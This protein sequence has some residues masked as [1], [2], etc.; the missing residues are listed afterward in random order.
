MIVRLH[1][2]SARA[3][4]P[5]DLG[6]ITALMAACDEMETGGVDAHAH[7][8]DMRK[9]WLAPGFNLQSDAWVIMSRKVQIV[10]YAS[11]YLQ[12]EALLSLQIFVH[13]E[14]RGRGIGTLLVWLAEERARQLM[15]GI[16]P[17]LRVS[18]S[19]TVC[20]SNQAALRLFEREGYKL[21]RGFW[22][23]AVEMD[24]VLVQ[25]FGELR[26]GGKLKLD[27]VVD[28]PQGDVT[29][30]PPSRTSAY[31]VHH[32]TVY[33]KELRAD[34]VILEDLRASDLLACQ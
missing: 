24:E 22:R 34:C 13:P 30:Q 26:Q 15:K 19:T 33:E 32:Y 27:V 18:L 5:T 7:E 6:A 3:P 25:S 12:E 2:L 29:M 31:S 17:D 8:E 20:S 23:L 28:A 1:N 14:Y 4:A 11:V 10:G 21:V 9:L 16:Q